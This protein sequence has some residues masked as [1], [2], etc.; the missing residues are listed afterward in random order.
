[1]LL[2]LIFSF[3]IYLF[4][5]RNSFKKQFS[6]VKFIVIIFIVVITNSH[7]SFV[8]VFYKHF[9]EHLINHLPK[10]APPYFILLAHFLQ[11]IV[12]LIS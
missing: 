2:L 7:V 11:Y 10:V 6:I 4:F 12:P 3:F 8:I 1:M 5:M 9:P